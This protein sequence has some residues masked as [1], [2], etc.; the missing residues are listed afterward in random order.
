MTE[1]KVLNIIYTNIGRGHPFYLDGTIKSLEESYREKVQLNIKDVFALSSGISLQLWK[2]VRW[3]YY[4]GSQ[5]GLIGQLYNS[6]RR[7]NGT[8]QSSTMLKLLAAG[9]RRF[10]RMN[11][12]PTLVAHPLLVPML[13]DLTKVY[14]QHGE[15]AVPPEAIVKDAKTIYVPTR[16]AAEA[17]INNG[18][19]DKAVVQTG[20]CIEDELA[21]EAEAFYNERLARLIQ[22]EIL[23]GGF[24]S[25]GA[26]PKQHIHKI[27]LMISSLRHTEQRGIVLCRRG[28]RLER[29]LTGELG[30]KIKD[31]DTPVNDIKKRLEDDRII[32]FS[33]S[34]R[35]DED[36][37]TVK[38]FRFIDYSVAPSHE[39]TN[40]ALGLGLPMFILHPTIGTF[41]PLN[42]Q[43]MLENKVA[44]DI[45]NDEKA[46]GFKS[47]LPS[48]N[49]QGILAGMARG[50]FGKYDIFG[51]GKTADHLAGELMV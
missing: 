29:I 2:T 27:A 4:R 36:R 15:N 13:A 8:S 39:R 21:Y 6:I 25:S 1:K 50:G 49:K 28:G 40:W 14:Y 32:A 41:S 30:I 48:L 42:R 7:G 43:L 24:F 22:N 47:I 23:T 18:I 38:L 35:P 37:L 17:F 51:F 44:L 45:E 19:D 11:P 26:E 20:L 9:T 46:V 16:Q 31:S 10:I 33:Y 12:Y 34:S 3:L 5:G